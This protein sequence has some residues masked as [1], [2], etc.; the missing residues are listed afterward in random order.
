MSASLRDMK[1][2]VNEIFTRSYNI[3][4]KLNAGGNAPVAQGGQ[5]GQAADPQVRNYLENIQN[6][7]SNISKVL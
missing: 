1:N 4:Q 2:Y 3:E 6:G 5:A 7:N